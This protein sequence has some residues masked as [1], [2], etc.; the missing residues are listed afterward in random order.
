MLPRFDEKLTPDFFRLTGKLRAVV[1][2][3]LLVLNFASYPMVD[4][5]ALD[6]GVFDKMFAFHTPMHIVD[7]LLGLWIWK[8]SLSPRQMRI[9]T[10][11]CLSIEMVTTLVVMY[12]FG[13]VSSHML[14]IAVVLLLTYRLAYD[15]WIGFTALVIVVAGHWAIVIAEVAGFLP[16]QPLAIGPVD[17][18]YLLPGREIGAMTFITLMM[19]LTFAIAH[20]A[21]ARFR[22][23][24]AAVR[25]LREQLYASDRHRVGRHSGRQ[26]GDVYVLGELLGTGGMGEVYRGTHRARDEDLAVKLLHPHLIDDASVL[27]RFRREAQITGALGSDHIVKVIDVGEDG[28]QPY[29]VL[30]YLD[31]CSLG[32]RLRSGGPIPAAELIGIASQLAAGLEAA[33]ESGVVHRD[34]KPENIY[35]VAR[36]E[37]TPLVK[38]LDFGVS[39]IRGHATTLT[40]QLALVGT[41]D[42]MSPEQAVGVAKHVGRPT[43]VF[44]FGAVLYTALTGA[45][46]FSAPSVP[47]L[48]RRIC[49]YEPV[50]ASQL[51]AVPEAVDSVLA[52]AMAK[53][54]KERYATATE[55]ARDF[56]VAARGELDPAVGERAARLHRGIPSRVVEQIGELADLSTV[57]TLGSPRA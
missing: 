56:A 14:I 40:K 49:E 21:V 29:L 7:A 17:T 3:C 39:K 1:T 45:R 42:Y 57:A 12:A 18:V 10:Y 22:Y 20:W 28:G 19:L 55:L 32:E 5:L 27:E 25:L 48:L 47:A 34:L 46:P 36:D 30:E 43:D 8:G 41:P 33:H 13:S 53:E 52:I 31:G 35:L 6:R 24:D 37:A 26:L 44:S 15:F 11:V 54:P 51:A 9:T 16:P 2:C 38:V 23:R 4:S 50:P